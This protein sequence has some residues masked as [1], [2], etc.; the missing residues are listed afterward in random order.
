MRTWHMKLSAIVR[1]RTGTLQF[2]TA[3]TGQARLPCLAG[4]D[5][6]ARKRSL[7]DFRLHRSHPHP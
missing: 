1:L 5:Y 4:K 3:W 2:F 7:R 6:H